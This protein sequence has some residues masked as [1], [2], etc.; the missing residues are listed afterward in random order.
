MLYFHYVIILHLDLLNHVGWVER[1]SSET[2]QL[3][4]I[5]G[6]RFAQPNLAKMAKTKIR[7]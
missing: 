3:L 4:K 1:Q 2:Q 6:F 7:T 5:V